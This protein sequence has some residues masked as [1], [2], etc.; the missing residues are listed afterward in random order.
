LPAGASGAHEL[1]WLNALTAPDESDLEAE[2]VSKAPPLPDAPGP[3]PAWMS[4]TPAESSIEPAW[5][6]TD[7]EPPT[8]SSAQG[9]QGPEELP[10]AA[11]QESGADTSA[12]H[13]VDD[14]GFP[15][16]PAGAHASDPGEQ[17]DP[18]RAPSGEYVAALEADWDWLAGVAPAV[19][20]PESTSSPGRQAPS[21]PDNG[22]QDDAAEAMGA[23][24]WPVDETAD[25]TPH[26]DP[27][28]PELTTASVGDA[29]QFDI[30]AA[31]S[32]EAVAQALIEVAARVRR[33]EL[34]VPEYRPQL[35]EAAALAAALAALL[36]TRD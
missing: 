27:L 33:G 30:G 11:V 13:P 25:E 29:H 26:G 34:P 31:E 9:I 5:L 22:G 1:A 19:A 4:A 35:G 8:A 14:F 23:E 3:E 10:D 36:N 7:E 18:P 6:V 15:D 32:S 20:A 16:A 24:R 21:G 28:R 12:R 2:T 17:A